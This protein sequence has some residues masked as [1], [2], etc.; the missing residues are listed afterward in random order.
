MSVIWHV[1]PAKLSVYP[2]VLPLVLF[3]KMANVCPAVALMEL[4]NE[5]PPAPIEGM[6]DAVDKPVAPPAEELI[7]EAE[8]HRMGAI[9]LLMA[10]QLLSVKSHTA[11][12]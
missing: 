6:L 11:K 1:E 2:L 12:S 8:L 3:T 9:P 7:K 10:E 4:L 5:P